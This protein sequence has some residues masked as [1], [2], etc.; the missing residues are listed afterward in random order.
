MKQYFVSSK[1]RLLFYIS[2]VFSL[3]AL[4]SGCKLIPETDPDRGATTVKQD[5]FGD[6]YT[7]IKY[8]E[9]GWDIADSMWFYTTTQGSNLMPYDFFYG[10]GEA[11]RIH[12]VSF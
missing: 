2:I 1:K 10:I 11:R 7:T 3:A 12:A 4:V 5:Q 8:L 6:S 9:Q